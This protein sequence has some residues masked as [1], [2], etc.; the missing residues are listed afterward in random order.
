MRLLITT[1]LRLVLDVEG[2][3]RLHSSDDTGSFGI[4]PGHSDFLTVPTASVLSWT[5]ADGAERHAALRGGVLRVTGGAQ[6]A[7]AARE[8]VI[9]DSIEDL[10]AAVVEAIRQEE[11]SDEEARISTARLHLATMRQL[12]RY[13]TA[14]HRGYEGGS[15]PGL[16]TALE[17]GGKA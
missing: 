11:K 6:V 3:T 12:Q 8:A 7:I 15:V 17:T 16:E 14:A 5:G 2:V 1:P 9:A 13:L 10:A 4:W